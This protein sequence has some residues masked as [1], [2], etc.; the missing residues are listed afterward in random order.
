MANKTPKNLKISILGNQE[1][2]LAQK[3]LFFGVRM[4]KKEFLGGWK[5]KNLRNY[6]EKFFSFSFSSSSFSLLNQN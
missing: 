2:N 4:T 5:E 1:S 6:F 3:K